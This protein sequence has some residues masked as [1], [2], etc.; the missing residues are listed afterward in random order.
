MTTMSLFDYSN[1]ASVAAVARSVS[2]NLKRKSTYDMAFI[3]NQ[4][5]K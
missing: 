1:A 2:N 4:Q 5:T 3:L